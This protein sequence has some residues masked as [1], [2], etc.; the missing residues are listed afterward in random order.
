MIP[1][2]IEGKDTVKHTF[3]E[4]RVRVRIRINDNIK[5]EVGA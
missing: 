2:S 4:S 5:I 3:K 1:L